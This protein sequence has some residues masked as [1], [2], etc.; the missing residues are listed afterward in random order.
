[1]LGLFKRLKEWL[2][3][4][5]VNDSDDASEEVEVPSSPD[6]TQKTM[7][8]IFQNTDY[9][10]NNM[11]ASKKRASRNAAI[12][13]T[14]KGVATAATVVGLVYA[15]SKAYKKVNDARDKIIQTVDSVKNAVDAA[16]NKVDSISQ[17]VVNA[18]KNV[19]NAAKET[20]QKV[21]SGVKYGVDM[22]KATLD[23][24]TT[25]PKTKY[26]ETLQKYMKQINAIDKKLASLKNEIDKNAAENVSS[27]DIRALKEQFNN[28]K[29]LEMSIRKSAQE[30]I[31]NHGSRRGE[32]S[33]SKN[34][35][36]KSNDYRQ[37]SSSKSTNSNKKSGSSTPEEKVKMVQTKYNE[38][39][40]ATNTKIQSLPKGSDERKSE[41]QSL[42]NKM[43][44]LKKAALS[45]K[46][47][48]SKTKEAISSIIVSIDKIIE[49]AQSM[50]K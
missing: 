49:K 3:G 42:V 1:M 8:R 19:K 13:T 50:T 29:E 48:E 15:G 12:K 31:A 36:G 28:L 35:N 41:A 2:F 17:P 39:V 21:K 26:Q 30:L 34:D 18:A 16:K 25:I 4:K 14:A 46:T 40:R 10:L 7:D 38:L 5:K 47:S 32:S 24:K 22:I 27:D 44:K 33:D 9:I 37:K 20:S 43:E 23:D 6:A 45:I 11:V